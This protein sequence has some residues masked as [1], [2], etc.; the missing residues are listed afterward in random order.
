MKNFTAAVV[1]MASTD[2][3]DE[4]LVRACALIDEAAERGADAAALPE[5][6]ALVSADESAKVRAAS[7]CDEIAEVI[8]GQ[9]RRR[10]MYILGGTIAYPAAGDKSK[11]KSASL[12]FSPA[13][14]I[15]ARYDKMHL[16][17]YR[18]AGEE[19]DEA[20]TI[21]PGDTVVCVAAPPARFGLSVCYDL[22]FPELYRAMDEPEVIF[23]PSAFTRP[24]G[25]AH[26]ELLLRARAVEN[27]SYLIAPAQGGEHPG[28]RRTWGHS[29]IVNPWGEVVARIDGEGEGVAVALIDAAV[30][31]QARAC[32]PA[33]QNRRIN[34]INGAS[35][36]R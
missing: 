1:Q 13:G 29:A 27:L 4:N 3:V 35:D 16:F 22:R 30:M 23:A 8:A 33:L 20:R 14:E 15:L 36:D 25:A 18:G 17:R 24:T 21:E 6:F 26:W 9:A 31:E 34:R 2:S 5:F 32:L 12:L 7:R 19:Y 28:G 10:K 11:V